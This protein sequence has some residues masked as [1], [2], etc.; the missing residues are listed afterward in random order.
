MQ[1]YEYDLIVLDTLREAHSGDENSSRDTSVINR[2]LQR[3]ISTGAAVDV[4]HHSGVAGE[5]PRG[6]TALFGNADVVIKVE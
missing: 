4:V 1:P 2:A 6:S 5:R 3:I